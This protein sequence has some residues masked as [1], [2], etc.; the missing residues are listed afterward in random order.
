LAF[1]VAIFDVISPAKFHIVS[2]IFLLKKVLECKEWPK[3]WSER[4]DVSYTNARKKRFWNAVPAWVL[5][6]KNFWNSV[7][8]QK[9]PCI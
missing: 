2:A 9:L 4:G 5:L 3:T 8:A 7:P 6:R 1:K